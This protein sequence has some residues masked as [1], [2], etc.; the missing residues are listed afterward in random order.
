MIM[1]VMMMRTTVSDSDYDTSD[2]QLRL[3]CQG[4]LIGCNLNADLDFT[5]L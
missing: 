1:M 4:G 5:L 3:V 2:R